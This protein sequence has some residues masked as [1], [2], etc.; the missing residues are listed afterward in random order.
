MAK[1]RSVN[2]KFWDDSY[3][4]NLD[5]HEKL[6]FLYLLTNPLTNICGAYEI[7][8]R[9]ISFDTGMVDSLL[10]PMLE[11]FSLSGRITYKDG[12][13]VIHNFIKNQSL[14]PKVKEG[15]KI[16]LDNAPKWIKDSLSIDLDS[17]SQS[18]SNSN[19]NYNAPQS[20]YRPRG[21]E[22]RESPKTTA[23]ETKQL[24]KKLSI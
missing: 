12:W 4:I 9:R 19:S 8:L 7:S 17:L 3:I 14:N 6:L 13:V 11:K 2:T 24:L 18:N 5:P 20:G 21:Q 22:H 10:E 15:I 16:G 1:M 23:E